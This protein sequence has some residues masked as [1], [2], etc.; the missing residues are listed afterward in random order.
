MLTRTWT[1]QL[2]LPID[3]K[4]FSCDLMS[5]ICFPFLVFQC[6]ISHMAGG[7]SSMLYSLLLFVATLSLQEMFRAK[8]ASSELFTILGGFTSSLI[9]LMLL[10]VREPAFLMI[11]VTYY[12]GINDR[13]INLCYVLL[14]LCLVVASYI[15]SIYLTHLYCNIL[16]NQWDRIKVEWTLILSFC[17]FLVFFTLKTFFLNLL[18]YQISCMETCINSGFVYLIYVINWDTSNMIV[19]YASDLDV[20]SPVH[21]KLSGNMWYQDRMGCR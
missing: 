8:L 17:T 16:C 2:Q 20:S 15:S 21:R 9:F 18:M 7:G 10:T 14:T 13:A 1:L 12:N 19:V 11:L 6:H 5:F 3:F 4:P